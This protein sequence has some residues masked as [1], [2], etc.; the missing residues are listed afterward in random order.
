M[1]NAVTDRVFLGRTGIA[2]SP[3]GFGAAGL[4]DM[5]ASYG[6]PVSEDR[7]RATLHAIF[8]GPSNFLDTS[9]NYGFGRSEER[10]GAVIRERGDCRTASSSPPSSTGT[11]RRTP[12]A[13]RR[14]AA[15]WSRA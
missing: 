7:A 14:R 3:I 13:P 2:V 11:W 9:R 8:D 5:P 12:S 10:I 1:T 15:R 6:Y 4:G